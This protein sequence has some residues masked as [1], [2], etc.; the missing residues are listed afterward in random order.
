MSREKQYSR[1]IPHPLF[2][3]LIAE[4]AMN[5]DEDSWKPERQ[6]DIGYF[7]GCVDFMDVEVKFSK[8][9]KGDADHASIAAASILLLN[10]AGIDPLVLDLNVF[11]C[12]GHDQLWQGQLEI[13]D[14]LKEHN[15]RRLK[16]SG[17]KTV[18]CSCAECY[19][20]FA[21]DYDLPNKIGIEV[22]HIT[23]TLRKSELKF[24]SP[25]NVR[26]AFHD[27]CRLGRMMGEYQAPR[28][29]I[30]IIENVEMVELENSKERALCCG[31][32]S[33]MYC[34]DATK[35]VRKK[36]L[37]QG[38]DQNIDVMLGGC[39]KC[40]MHMQCLLNEER[41]GEDEHAHPFEMMDLMQFLAACLED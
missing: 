36:R 6:H 10:K 5:K 35:A 16:E 12:S 41:M 17:I 23:Q 38:T 8:L 11:K 19:R 21:V 13:F 27:P 40:Y 24:K 31:V 22:E 18:T 37:D 9:N 29:L 2:E 3:R 4:D 7:P 15:M 32:S 1:S 34:N 14:A 30:Q 25:T 39:P 20:T 26:V 28:D 33:M